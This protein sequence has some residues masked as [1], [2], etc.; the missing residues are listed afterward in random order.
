M[1]L[2]FL[3]ERDNIEVEHKQRGNKGATAEDMREDTARISFRCISNTTIYSFV[4]LHDDLGLV[5]PRDYSFVHV[6]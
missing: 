6:V 4:V 3:P 1:P 2:I 5:Q